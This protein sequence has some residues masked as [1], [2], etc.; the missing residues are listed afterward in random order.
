MRCAVI[1][2]SLCPL[3]C[4]GSTLHIPEARASVIVYGVA[5]NSVDTNLIMTHRKKKY[6]PFVFPR[7][8]HTKIFFERQRIYI[9]SILLLKKT[10]I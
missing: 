6:A 5:P 4:V 9:N 7:S 3:K 8:S 1:N 10:I 2:N